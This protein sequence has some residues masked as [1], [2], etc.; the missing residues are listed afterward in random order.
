MADENPFMQTE[1]MRPDFRP[2]SRPA[3]SSP[4]QSGNPLLGTDYLTGRQSAPTG[5]APPGLSPPGAQPQQAPFLT[6]GRPPAQDMAWSEVG[7]QAF[8]NAPKS[9]VEFGKALVQPFLAPVETAKTIRQLGQGL[10]S[11]GRGLVG[12]ERDLAS[13]GVADAM[14]QFFKDRYGDMPSIK[15]TLA[16]DPV[17]AAADFSTILTGGGTLAAKAPGI[18]GKAGQAAR[19]VG[20]TIDP[21]A[22]ATKAPAVASKAVTS[23]I[24]VPLS[25]QSGA[26]Y[27]SL[28][29]AA[30]AG[31]TA[32][33][34]FWEHLS[35]SVPAT[36]LVKRVNDG[37][38]EVAKQRSAEYMA[39]MGRIASTQSLPFDKVDDALRAARDVAYHRGAV[40]NPEAAA[41]LQRM[42]SLV[43]QWRTNPQMVHNIEDFDKLKQ[44]LRNTGYAETFKGSPARKVVDDIANAAR[45]TIPD[46]RYAGIM[47]NYQAATQELADLTKELTARGGSSITQIRKIL[48]SQDTKAKG[49]LL[50]RLEQI[51]PDLPYAIAGVELNP[52]IPQGIRGQIAGMLASG[53]LT[54]IAALAA[55]PAPLAGLALSSPRVVGTTSYGM[56]RAG[57]ALENLRQSR[58]S[59]GA[60]LF[61]SGRT[62]EVAGQRASGG[63]V[64]RTTGGRAPRISDRLLHAVERARREIQSETK[65]ILDAPD[66]TVVRALEVAKQH[67]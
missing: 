27:R 32:N 17:G 50:K 53:S 51:D 31:A 49:D 66:E 65:P 55:H 46:K 9:A 62:E 3:P 21:L 24:N 18:I 7:S 20:S 8:Q 16:E 29:H 59:A 22:I 43:R 67:I 28:Q 42:E 63:R 38:S 6:P 47:E 57:N 5:V 15:R 26:S 33:P 64:G 14:G 11:K 13:E 39:G 61:Q 56:G 52:L 41:A 23:A 44:A 1:F 48:R 30:K 4:S 60:A 54:G 19:A 10:Y 37:I 25:L 35:G 36:D 12:Y 45:E 2:S 34:V 40:V 58:P